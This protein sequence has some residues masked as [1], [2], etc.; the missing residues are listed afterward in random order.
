MWRSIQDFPGYETNECGDVRSIERVITCKDGRRMKIHSRILTQSNY[1]N[2]YHFV[3]LWK[4][5]KSFMLYA[6]RVVAETFLPNPEN[7]PVV[8]HKNGNKVDNRIQNLEWVTYS[9]NNTHAYRTG[10]KSACTK[11]DEDDVRFIRRSNDTGAALCRHFNVSPATISQIRNY[12][13]RT[14][15]GA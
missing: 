13:T 11:L 14:K 15:I 10:L 9:E 1:G 4:G 3:T 12:K 5:N 8:N 2:G 6:H 7:L